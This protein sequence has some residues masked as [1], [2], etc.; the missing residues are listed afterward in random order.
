VKSGSWWLLFTFLVTGIYTPFAA[1]S[2]INSLSARGLPIQ[3][4]Q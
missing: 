4:F 3:E 1:L 2:V